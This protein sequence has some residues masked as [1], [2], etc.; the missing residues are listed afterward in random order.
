MPSALTFPGQ[1]GVTGMGHLLAE[2]ER[3][4][5]RA[6]AFALASRLSWS[7][8]LYEL[9]LMTANYAR[10]RDCSEG[11]ELTLLTPETRPLEVFGDRASAVLRG[12]LEQSGIGLRTNA[13]PEGYDEAALSLRG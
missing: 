9:A 11:L 8:P 1:V 13:E 10:E 5:A 2:I 7:L 3:G 6:V 4:E 12:R